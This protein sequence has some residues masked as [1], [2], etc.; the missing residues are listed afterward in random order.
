MSKKYVPEKM[1]AKSRFRN[2]YATWEP[3]NRLH[4][5]SRMSQLL[6]ENSEYADSKNYSHMCNLITALAMEQVLEESGKPRRE[7]QETV[8]NVMYDFLKPM[9]P[10]MQKLA[11]LGSFVRILK[12]TMPIKFENTVGHGWEVEFPK[13]PGD[14]YSLIT[15]RCIYHD[16]F[17]RYGMPEFTAVFCQVDDMMYSELPRAEFIYTQQIGRG[18]DMC[19]YS[20]R[21]R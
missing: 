19:D 3:D 15:H 9:V 6:E 1:I 12:I 14:T 16:I 13:C 5:I 20:F 4:L 18:G 2:Y 11:S 7:A 8:A 21:K 17:S 10:K